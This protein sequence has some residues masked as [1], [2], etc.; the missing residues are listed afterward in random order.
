MITD[1]I[2]YLIFWVV[3]LLVLGLAAI[4]PTGSLPADFTSAVETASGYLTALDFVL[5]VATLVSILGVF[6]A[7]EGAIFAYKGVM[8]VIRKIPTIG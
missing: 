7:F 8:W 3:N 2:L 4:L 1:A 6:L 5:P